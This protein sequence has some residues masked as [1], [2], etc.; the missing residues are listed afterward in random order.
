MSEP[1]DR[2]SVHFCITELDVG[3]AE[4]ALVKI[5]TGLKELGW[6]ISVTSLRDE[7]PLTADLRAADIDVAALKCG[8]FADVR[9]L[10]RLK[11]RLREAR[12][13]IVCSFL[14]QANIYSRLA[15]PSGCVVVS[16]IRVADRRLSVR[17]PEKWTHHKVDQYVAVSQSVAAVHAHLCGIPAKRMTSIPNGV[18]SPAAMPERAEQ[19]P[20][21]VLFVGRLTE[22]KDPQALL[23]A[24]EALPEDVRSG[25]KLTFVGDGP[26]RTQLQQAAN[27]SS[28]ADAI[29]FVGQV[30]DVADRMQAATILAL[31]SKWEGMPNVVLEAMANGLPVVATAV[32]GTQEAID[33]E[34]GWLVPAGDVSALADSICEA[35]T[36]PS[37]R[38]ARA[39]R[40]SQ[41]VRDKFTWPAVVER[42]D[43]LFRSLKKR[44]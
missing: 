42:Y 19:K 38:A 30:S 28:C 10:P 35:L 16:G 9:C 5:A 20:N 43:K 41:R 31:P 18:D 29:Q 7:G 36:S 3:G 21:E 14:H 25:S 11:R 6:Q 24:F 34:T 40:A 32:D 44:A 23:S 39:A 17:W 4:R 13:D 26:L 33:S 37:E 15:A 2:T 12:A 27:Q 1:S 22:Q 8:G